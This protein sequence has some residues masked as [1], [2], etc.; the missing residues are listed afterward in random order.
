M[1]LAVRRIHN[2]PPHLSYVSTLP[3]IFGTQ[4]TC[5][6]FVFGKRTAASFSSSVPSAVCKTVSMNGV[7]VKA[8]GC[9]V[10]FTGWFHWCISLEHSDASL[11]HRWNQPVNKTTY[12]VWHIFLLSNDDC[13]C[14]STAFVNSDIVI[15]K[16]TVNF[17]LVCTCI[18]SN[19]LR[20]VLKY[21]SWF[22]Y[23]SWLTLTMKDGLT[24]LLKLNTI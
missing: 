7:F 24:S 4:C 3:D 6:Y 11:M 5:M 12:P 15:Y 10:L 13:F 21:G 2:L 22:S 9:V 14:E 17:S 1:T 23:M 18:L 20:D 19:V 16:Q 8:C